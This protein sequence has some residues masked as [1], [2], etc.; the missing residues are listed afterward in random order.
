MPIQLLLSLAIIVCGNASVGSV[1]FAADEGS[2]RLPRPDTAQ[3]QPDGLDEELLKS[4][5]DDEVDLGDKPEKNANRG[6]GS[7]ARDDGSSDLDEELMRGLDDGEDVGEENPLVK[8]GRQMRQVEEWIAG[9]RSGTETQE[10]QKRI[11][12]ELDK[13][14]KQAQQQQQQQS[15]SKSKNQDQQKDSKRRQVKQPQSRKEQQAKKSQNPAQQST[16][17]LGP[18]KLLNPDKLAVS[19]LIKRVWG[20]LPEKEREQMSQHSAELFLPQYE[21]LITEYFKTLVEK[22]KE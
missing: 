21:Q 15:Q 2:E 17:R 11:A 9:G 7:S 14:L 3:E 20:Q 10:L 4:L 6:D 19:D 5:G 16:E 18:D 13:L 1:L 12:L 22:Q 8:V